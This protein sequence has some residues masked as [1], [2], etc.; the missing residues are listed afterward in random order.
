VILFL[1]R[2]DHCEGTEERVFTDSWTGMSLCLMCLH[3]VASMITMS[4]AS[5]GD[6]LEEVL[7][8]TFSLGSL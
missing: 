3:P 1:Q 2:C 4:P 5:E 8:H 7:E 6:N